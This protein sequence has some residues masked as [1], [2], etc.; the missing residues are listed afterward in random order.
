[1]SP[2]SKLGQFRCRQGHLHNGEA[3]ATVFRSRFFHYSKRED[4]SFLVVRIGDGW[5]CPG[6]VANAFD[7]TN[8]PRVPAVFVAEQFHGLA[9]DVLDKPFLGKLAG[10]HAGA[11]C[12][13]EFA[14]CFVASFR[15]ERIL[16]AAANQ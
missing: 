14:R 2:Q 15:Q 1:M 8:H 7:F 6:G 10:G 5:R 11:A 3:C 12:V 9:I 16:P 4:L 13:G